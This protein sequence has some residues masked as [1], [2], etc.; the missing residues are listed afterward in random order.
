[1]YFCVHCTASKEEEAKKRITGLLGSVLDD[2]FLVWFPMKEV[3]EKRAGKYE[4]VDKPMFSGYLF[5]YWEGS[6]EKKFP[7]YEMKRLPTVINILDY[8]D[9]S[10]AL[11]GKDM[12]FARWLHMHGGYIRQSK[13]IYREGQRIHICDGPLKGFDGNVVKV[14]KHHKRIVLRFDIGGN[15]SDVSFTVDF[16]DSNNAVNARPEPTS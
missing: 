5:M 2:E 14:D 4:T 16:L 12:E 15:V 9:G 7:I 10:H 1:M 6:D 3:K 13:V 8:D 11:K